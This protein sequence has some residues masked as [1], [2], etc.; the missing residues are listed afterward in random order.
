MKA[1]LTKLVCFALIQGAYST[2][3]AAQ[4]ESYP[5]RPVRFVVPFAPGGTTDI[6]A[7][8]VGSALSEYL[9]QQFVVDNRGG[10][11]SSIGTAIAARAQ[12][13]GYTIILNNNGLAINETLYDKL[14]YSA[15]KDLAPISLVGETPNALIVNNAL[16]VKTVK[17]FVALARTSPG[18]LTYASAGIGSSTHL[19]VAL[20]ESVAG[21]KAT[22]VP[23]KGGA[24]ALNDTISGQVQFMLATLPSVHSHIM[25]GRVKALGVSGKERSP[26]L[27]NVPTIAQSGYPEFV[28]TSWYGILVPAATPNAIVRRL[29]EVTVKLVGTPAVADRL[30]KQGLEPRTTTPEAFGTM[31]RNE[32]DVWQKIIKSEN[33]KQDGG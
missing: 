7:R 14:P 28:Y 18:K 6:I 31:I 20:F 29:N 25:S 1:I 8:I 23:Y 2:A 32:I 3:S 5:Q 4:Q 12:A 9:G 15:L 33:I 11:G 19:S 13:D 10:A 26:S 24:P 30:K 17:E 21:F 22:H 27:P 16:P